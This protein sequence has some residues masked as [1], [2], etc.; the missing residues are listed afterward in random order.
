MR[1]TLLATLSRP[2]LFELLAWFYLSALG[3]ATYKSDLNKLD[4]NF[5]RSIAIERDAILNLVLLLFSGG[6][7]NNSKDLLPRLERL[8]SDKLTEIIAA[9]G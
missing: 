7:L 5:I 1:D 2:Q 6:R 8:Y 9:K 3:L 4:L